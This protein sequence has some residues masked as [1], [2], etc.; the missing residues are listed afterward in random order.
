MCINMSASLSLSLSLSL[1][2]FFCPSAYVRLLFCCPVAGSTATMQ[3]PC[4]ISVFFCIVQRSADSLFPQLLPLRF[5]FCFS[6]VLTVLVQLKVIS[7]SFSHP[8]YSSERPQT[9]ITLALLRMAIWD[10]LSIFCCWE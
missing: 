4:V 1:S 2:V 9:F 5:P 3:G 8:N 10:I 7:T 6:S